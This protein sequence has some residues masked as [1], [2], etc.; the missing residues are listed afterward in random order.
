MLLSTGQWTGKEASGEAHR[1]GVEEGARVGL[2]LPADTGGGEHVGRH[3]GYV[4]N[5]G[6]YPTRYDLTVN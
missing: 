6:Q 3:P 2:A 1:G 4:R 5:L